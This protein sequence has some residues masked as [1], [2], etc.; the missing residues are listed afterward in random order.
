M[1]EKMQIVFPFQMVNKGS[2]V[3]L[4]GAGDV[5]QAYYWELMKSRYAS[6]AGWVDKSWENATELE[7]PYV[8]LKDISKLDYDYVVIAVNRLDIAEQIKQNLQRCGVAAEKIIYDDN[9]VMHYEPVNYGKLYQNS[10]TLNLNHNLNT[11]S[12]IRLGF[13][14]AANIANTIAETIMQKCPFIE[15]YAVASREKEKA[16]R[17]AE[18]WGAKI[19]YD[20]YTALLKDEMVDLIYI[21]SPVAY[22]YEHTMM[23]LEEGKH[24]VCEKPFAVNYKQ[25]RE[26]VEAAKKRNLFLT[27]GLWTAYLPLLKEIKQ[28]IQEGELGKI[29]A[30]MADQ[31]YFSLNNL[32][33]LDYDLCGGSFLEAGFYL[34]NFVKTILGDNIKDIY[35][36]TKKNSSGIDLQETIILQYEE[37]YACINSGMTAV[38]P[39]GGYVFG[40]KGYMQ[41]RDVNEYKELSVYNRD[42]ELVKQVR[43]ESGYQYEIY[44]WQEALL[45]QKTET[46]ERTNQE[47][48]QDMML[49]DRIRKSMDLRYEVDE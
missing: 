3:V 33:L 42:G 24:V 17:F 25:A 31:Y 36:V 34:I 16:K 28:I 20:S 7:Y 8:S 5:G 19:V 26:M 38:S 37:N 1:K 11:K 35:T 29:S 21:A 2:K 15:I 46:T 40:E 13:L 48:L 9:S 43:R 44:A 4:Y 45:N 22:H 14:T 18:K 41:I 49:M 30:V 32:R 39:R 10:N 12:T 6:V 47:I 27:D 23:A